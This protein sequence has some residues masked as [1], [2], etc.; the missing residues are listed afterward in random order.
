MSYTMAHGETVAI[1]GWR[2]FMDD[3]SIFSSKMTLFEN[4]PEGQLIAVC[5]FLDKMANETVRYRHIYSGSGDD[6]FYYDPDSDTYGR[7][8]ETSVILRA[9]RPNAVTKRG[10]RKLVNHPGRREAQAAAVADRVW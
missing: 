4:L 7:T 9:A 3:G 6:L 5:L 1:L 2:A 8:H 10:S